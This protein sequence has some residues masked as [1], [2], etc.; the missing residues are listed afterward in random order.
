MR[1]LRWNWAWTKGSFSHSKSSTL[2]GGDP[3]D[4]FP[5][6]QRTN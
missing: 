6:F 3:A 5:Q 2:N 1:R 4:Q